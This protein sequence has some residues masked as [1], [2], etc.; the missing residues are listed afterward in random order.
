MSKNF[1]SG[2]KISRFQPNIAAK[3]FSKRLD[4]DQFRKSCLVNLASQILP[5]AKRLSFSKE[6]VKCLEFGV[7]LA[8]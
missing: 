5:K 1:T 8:F 7:G 4:V 6:S 2:S 3:S